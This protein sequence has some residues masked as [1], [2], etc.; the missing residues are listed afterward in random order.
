MTT[1]HMC[2][3]EKLEAGQP[4]PLVS[5]LVSSMIHHLFVRL[6]LPDGVQQLPTT[7]ASSSIAALCLR[8]LPC[9]TCT[10]QAYLY[11]FLLRRPREIR[12]ALHVMG[13]AL[14]TMATS[15]ATASGLATAI[16]CC[17]LHDLHNVARFL[18]TA[19]CRPC[20]CQV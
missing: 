20:T 8:T 19:I 5:A 14:A 9:A 3:I 18:L 10:S 2:S 1:I 11:P 4:A 16:G 13:K 6:P 12:A 15:K 17:C 7:T